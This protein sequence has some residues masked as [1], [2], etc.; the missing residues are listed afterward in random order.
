VKGARHKCSHIAWFHSTLHSFILLALRPPLTQIF[1]RVNLP[2]LNTSY[3]SSCFVIEL[4]HLVSF[5]RFIHVV[6]YFKIDSLLLTRYVDMQHFIYSF[7][8]EYLNCF[9]VSSMKI[10]INCLCKLYI[11]IYLHFSLDM[12][13]V[14]ELQIAYD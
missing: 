12:N 9:Y 3:N 11:G 6:A 13:R 8:D 14:A 5:S 4:F 1:F 7:A 2:A 10:I